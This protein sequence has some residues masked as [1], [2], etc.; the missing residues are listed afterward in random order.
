MAWRKS[1]P[2]LIERFGTLVPSD[3]RVVRKSMFGY[4][5]AVLGGH[6]FMGLHQEN[7][8]LRLG[9][10]GVAEFLAQPGAARFEPMPGR[11]M[12]GFVVAPPTLIASESIYVWIAR[13]LAHAASMPAKTAKPVKRAK[14]AQVA[15]PAKIAKAAKAAKASKARPAGKKPGKTKPAKGKKK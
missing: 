11:P 10:E 2:E 8:V 3:R 14:T 12:S 13:S 9:D 1:S 5:C 15:K 7:L 6:M 4:P